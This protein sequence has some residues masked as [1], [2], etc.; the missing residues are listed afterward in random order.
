MNV[1]T[2]VVILRVPRDHYRN[3]WSALTSITSIQKTPSSINVIHIGGIYIHVLIIIM[4]I[5]IYNI[6]RDN[7][8]LS[9][10]PNK[11]QL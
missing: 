3:V 7:Q 2:S 5:R 8:V 11:I 1:I 9:E 10:T 6:H 4:Y